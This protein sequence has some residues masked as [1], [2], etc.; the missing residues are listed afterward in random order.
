[1]VKIMGGDAPSDFGAHYELRDTMGMVRSLK[2][3]DGR[4]QRSP[5][6]KYSAEIIQEY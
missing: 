2:H 5:D 4:V 3:I 6:G 1:V